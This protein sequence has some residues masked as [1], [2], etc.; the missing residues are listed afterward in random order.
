MDYEERQAEWL[1]N[2]GMKEG[3][4]V[5]IIGGRDEWTDKAQ[6]DTVG[7]VGVFGYADSGGVLVRFGQRC[8]CNTPG[9]AYGWQYPFYLLTKV[10]ND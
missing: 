7:L 8:P 10:E 4:R 1:K 3:D 6:K 5:L 2:S 9:C